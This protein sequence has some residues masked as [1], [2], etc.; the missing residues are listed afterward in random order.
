[1][2][3][4]HEVGSKVNLGYVDIDTPITTPG[5]MRTAGMGP[6]RSSR[7]AR[8][9]PVDGR[10]IGLFLS[11]TATIRSDSSHPRA[12]YRRKYITPEGLRLQGL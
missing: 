11:R 8:V 3:R 2:R 1:M 9:M 7:L 6:K 4:T 5:R 10:A 12:S